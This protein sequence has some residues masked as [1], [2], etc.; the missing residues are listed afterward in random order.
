MR[1]D[2]SDRSIA[3][4][5]AVVCVLLTVIMTAPAA[6]AAYTLLDYQSP[7][8]L[9]TTWLYTGKDW[10]GNPSE[11]RVEVLDTALAI[12]TVP[13]SPPVEVISL[14]LDVG[15]SDNSGQFVSS[16]DWR[17]YVSANGSYRIWGHDD[18]SESIRTTGLD[19]GA[20]L[21]VGQTKFSEVPVYDSGVLVGSLHGEISLLGVENVTVPAATFNGCLH[22][23][24]AV[25][26]VLNQVWDEWWAPGIGAV[27]MVGISGDGSGRLRELVKHTVEQYD[28]AYEGVY[29]YHKRNTPSA[30]I[31]TAAYAE[32]EFL[33]QPDN[34]PAAEDAITSFSV[35]PPSG[36]CTDVL[37]EKYQYSQVRFKDSNNDGRI[38]PFSEP[39][40][41]YMS[42]GTDASCKVASGLPPSGQYQFQA[43]LAN[44]QTLTRSVTIT[45]PYSQSQ[46][47]PVQNLAAN[48]DSVGNELKL[49]WDIPSPPGTYPAGT[50]IDIRI[51]S[52][53]N[54]HYRSAQVRITNL[55]TT[56]TSFTLTPVMTEPFNLKTVDQL[57]IEVRHYVPGNVKAIARG[58]FDFDGQISG[59]LQEALITMTRLD[60]DGNGLTGL[61]E[62]I[63]SLQAVSNSPSF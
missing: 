51:Y 19:F 63:Y 30:N 28:F 36:T 3:L 18:G 17:E 45:V 61:P 35:I 25:S 9:G 37:I 57:R 43:T 24:V 13:G 27:K 50:Y 46:A 16:D 56:L 58:T 15:Y 32:T 14:R 11:T 29:T 4:S 59:I 42:H 6:F 34:Q 21:D 8:A 22:L 1:K 12:T 31:E 33:R 53:T 20:T 44:G 26:G 5:A 47:P 60:V 23:R 40:Y 38:D 62:A 49:T 2:R 48:W 55:P 10:D 7:L 52:Y 39:P 41:R 54:G